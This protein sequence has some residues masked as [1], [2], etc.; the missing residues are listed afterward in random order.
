MALLYLARATGQS[1][2]TETCNRE[3][4]PSESRLE[5]H[6][7]CQQAHLLTHR[8]NYSRPRETSPN[9]HIK[10]PFSVHPQA[11]QLG[12]THPRIVYLL[13]LQIY[14]QQTQVERT[15][16]A[17]G[18]LQVRPSLSYLHVLC[19]PGESTPVCRRASNG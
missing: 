14:H 1:I 2:Q 11:F 9:L 19:L 4:I 16:Y 6:P 13:N 3:P 8:I 18:G 10:P 7:N 17:L 15:L 12:N 5:C